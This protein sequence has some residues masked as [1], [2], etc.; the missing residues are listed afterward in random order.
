M[1]KGDSKARKM[2]ESLLQMNVLMDFVKLI[3]WTGQLPDERPASCIIV[4]P[5]GAGKTTVL[6][7]LQCEQAMFVTDLTARPLGQIV[8]GNE[9]LS[10]ILLGDFMALF[11]HKDST[12]KLTLQTVARLTGETLEMNPW[13]GATMTPRQ[14]GLITAIPPEDFAEKS[15]AKHFN[16]GG[17]ASRFI[18]IKY[19]YKPST[20]AAIHRFISENKY[21]Q[22][23]SK[24]FKIENPG[25]W[26]I[27]IPM[28]IANLIKDFGT[29]I[30][31]DTLGFRVHRHLRALVK[32]DARRNNQKS[33]NMENFTRIESYCEFFTQEGKAI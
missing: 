25:K 27:H 29:T 2:A 7:S 19:T 28:K 18:V 22:N 15:V 14:M 23:G 10:H 6:Q 20:I 1:K 21:S 9:K 32:A 3:V 4:A 12:V 31:D 33:V 17:F 11:G 13:T 26:V 8:T 30:S 5:P 16:S 24:A